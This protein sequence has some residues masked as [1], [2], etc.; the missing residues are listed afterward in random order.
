METEYLKIRLCWWMPKKV[1]Q[2]NRSSSLSS[3]WIH[4]RR[5]MTFIRILGTTFCTYQPRSRRIKP[6]HNETVEYLIYYLKTEKEEE[7]QFEGRKSK[8][9]KEE[10]HYLMPNIIWKLFLLTC[11]E[12]EYAEGAFSRK[13]S[14]KAVVDVQFAVCCFSA[15]RNVQHEFLR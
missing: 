6:V 13:S 12:T 3:K 1:Q 2:T 15:L 11:H 5:L 14:L 9:N 10:K 8:M 7:N 4:C